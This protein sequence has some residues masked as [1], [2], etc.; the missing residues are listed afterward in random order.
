VIICIYARAVSTV[1]TIGVVEQTAAQYTRVFF[2]HYFCR[3]V[4]QNNKMADDEKKNNIREALQKLPVVQNEDML[5]SD[6]VD[7]IKMHDSSLIQTK[8]TGY[9]QNPVDERDIVGINGVSLKEAIPIDVLGCD[10][11]NTDVTKVRTTLLDVYGTLNGERPTVENLRFNVKK[12][13]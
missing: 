1:R 4:S 6:V 2:C 12:L 8:Q 7:N 9:A 10:T 11:D 13:S 3:V 5:W